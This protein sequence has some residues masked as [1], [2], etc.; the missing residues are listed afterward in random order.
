MLSYKRNQV[1]E[2][3][4]KVIGPQEAK[5]SAAL[6]IRIKRLLETD[7]ALSEGGKGNEN[8]RVSF[9]FFS[10]KAP[11][12]GQ[13][14]WFSAYEAFALL[15]GLQ[16]MGHG[17]P[18]GFAVKILR[19]VREELGQAYVES[20]KRDPK[21]LFDKK[22]IRAKLRPGDALFSN[23][24]PFLLTI[25]SAYGAGANIQNE[26]AAFGVK[27]GL[28]EAFEFARKHQKAAGGGGS[29]MFDVVGSAHAINA[30]LAETKPRARGRG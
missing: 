1:E 7:R 28:E 10:E 3:I 9:A 27:R 5:P 6:Q 21:W 18:Q 20:L 22:D 29:T 24:D 13:E 4:S 17:W 19:N 11:G 15:I 30:K 23:Q 14:I 12:S 25:V 16:L 8:P 26:S 2:A